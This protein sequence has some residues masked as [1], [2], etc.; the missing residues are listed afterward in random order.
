MPATRRRL[1]R[2]GASLLVSLSLV[3]SGGASAF[4]ASQMAVDI[5][6]S[7]NLV[8]RG[9]PVSYVISVGNIG[10]STV[11]HVT[12]EAVTPS[13]F[14]YA[15]ALTTQGTCN[16]APAV[17]PF[18]ALGQY[19]PG[20]PS[21]VVLI[22]NTSPTAPVGTFDFVVT[23]KAGE[24]GSDR[25]HSAH[26]DTFT[27]LAA[28]TVLEVN[29][30]FSIHYI[31]P[32]GDSITTG[33][34]L[35]ATA[36]S[37][38][39]PQSTQATVPATSFGLPAWVAERDDPNGDLCPETDTDSCFGQVSEISVGAGIELDPYLIVQVRYD[40]LEVRGE[41]HRKLVIIHWF[42][43]PH[44]PPYEEIASICSDATPAGD[45]LPCRLPVQ[46]MDDRDWLVTIYLTSNGF[47]IGKG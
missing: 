31:V 8:T 39:N 43:A 12:L 6:S 38:I 5:V 15:R 10:S 21:L 36:L 28:T 16:V 45:E 44:D 20:S 40:Y 34:I 22:F 25:P 23:V 46:I 3:L 4:G 37:P 33:A 17:D 11:N 14:T 9:E 30:D 35:G 13:G 24:G 7:P 18:C 29:Q 41:N 47:V 19:A 26:V 42:D 1:L 32:E 27:D 2:L